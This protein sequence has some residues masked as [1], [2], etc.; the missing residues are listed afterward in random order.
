MNERK[1]ERARAEVQVLRKL[2][3]LPQTPS[4]PVSNLDRKLHIL[5]AEDNDLI[6]LLTG[7]LLQRDG[8]VVH[9]VWNGREAVDA[10]KR[11]RF[12]LVLMDI[13]MPEMD[14]IEA[15]VR[16]RQDERERGDSPCVIWAMT[17]TVDEQ[18]ARCMSAGANGTF[19]K[20]LGFEQL[21]ARLKKLNAQ[22][23][24]QELQ[25]TTG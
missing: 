22:P 6:A 19:T 14:G 10:M 9:R 3:E 15:T 11:T 8:H 23:V 21:R 4:A 20:P 18:L 7:K 12:D 2:F 5:V 25:R 24:M 13:Q 1:L 17:A 16:I